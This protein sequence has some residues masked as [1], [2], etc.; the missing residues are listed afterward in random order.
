MDIVIVAQYLLDIT[1]T[2][3]LNSRFV[4]LGNLLKDTHQVEIVTSDFIHGRKAHV[5]PVDSYRGMKL[6][7]LHEA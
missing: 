4:Y 3:N 7:M 2:E 6:T 5:Q 1:G